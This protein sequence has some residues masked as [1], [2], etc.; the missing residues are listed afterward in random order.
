MWIVTLPWT[1]AYL[2]Y[3]T[4]WEHWARVLVVALIVAVHL[5]ISAPRAALTR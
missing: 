3:E 1:V 4:G 2:A 5:S